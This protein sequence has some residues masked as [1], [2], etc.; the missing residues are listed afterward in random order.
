MDEDPSLLFEDR[1]E[2][3]IPLA[4]RV[5]REDRVDLVEELLNN[6]CISINQVI[7]WG[8]TLLGVASV[9]T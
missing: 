7:G 4:G 8:I 9:R 2:D 3:P 5:C 1:W 6:G